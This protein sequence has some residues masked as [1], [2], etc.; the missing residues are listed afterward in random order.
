MLPGEGEEGVQHMVGRRL[1]GKE[2][3]LVEPLCRDEGQHVGIH[4]K[5][6]S[7]LL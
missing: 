5:A 2:R 1:L 6:G 3:Q 7:G 4:A